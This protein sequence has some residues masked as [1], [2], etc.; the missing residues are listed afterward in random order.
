MKTGPVVLLSD[1]GL[2]D[3]YAGVMKGVIAAGAPKARVL[4]LTH[5]IP[6]QDVAAAA[7]ALKISVPYFASGALFVC[8]VD[9]GVGSARRILWARSARHQFLAPDNGLLAWLEGPDALIEARHVSN[10]RLYAAAVSGTF[11]GRDVFAPV[12]ARLCGGL[13]PAALGP[14]VEDWR[15]P[16]MPLPARQ[17]AGLT[18]EVLLIDRF[19]NAVT[20]I[21]AEEAAG[22]S[23]RFGRLELGP[24]R[25]HYAEAPEGACLALAGSS[26]YVELA[27]RNGNFAA[28]TKARRGD[29]VD[30][31]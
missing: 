5:D 8:V 30:V 28:R 3:V 29:P 22:K 4:D 15:K 31:R 16:A 12:A 14:L 25:G 24:V 26:G 17:K 1:F 23:V 27:V 18:G 10:A 19:G 7:F 13:P 9:P 2:S 20:N 6:A 21:R 11:H